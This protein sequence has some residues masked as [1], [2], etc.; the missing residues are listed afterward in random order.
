MN[1]MKSCLLLILLLSVHLLYGQDKVAPKPQYVII[2]NNEI[3]SKEKL[4]AYAKQGYVKAMTK[5]VSEEERTRLAKQLGERVGSKEFIILISLFTEEE[6]MERERSR[7]TNT[8]ASDSTQKEE[9]FILKLNDSVKDFTVTM[10]DG[11]AIKLS[12]LKGKVVL[13]NFWATWCAP[14]LMEFY[15][16]PSKIIAP[17]QNR[18]FVLLAISRGESKEKVVQKM[19]ALKKDGIDFNVGIDPDEQIWNLF[20]KGAIP[21]NF[22]I[23]QNGIIRYVSTGY[24]DENIEKLAKE[25]KKLLDQ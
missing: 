8:M 21:K 18:E 4:D 19:L 7:D 16:F 22:L 13:I 1:H 14:C 12:Q 23:D 11:K 2:I 3:V 20:A 15:D 9:E 25:I 5:G 17:F 10:I 6:K 24:A